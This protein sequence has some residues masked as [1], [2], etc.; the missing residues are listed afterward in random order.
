MIHI[1]FSVYLIG[2]VLLLVLPLDWVLSILFSAIFHE[3]CHILALRGFKG[4]ILEI[5]VNIGG[6]AICTGRTGEMGQFLSI[7]AGPLGSLSLLLLRR[8]A[9]K[10]AVCGLFHGLYN[11]IP[12]LPLDGGRLLRL[13]LYQKQPH[14]ADRIMDLIALVLCLLIVIA[15]IWMSV[16]DILGP[17]PLFMAV[18]WIIRFLPRKRPCKPPEIGVQ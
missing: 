8:F 12:V 4:K 9:P 10:I 17:W 6:C 1:H 14:K 11:L 13:L 16:I 3:L 15:A 2:A 5:K 18:A 7:L